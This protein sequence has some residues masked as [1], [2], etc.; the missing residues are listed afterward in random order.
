MPRKELTS[1]SP[2]GVYGLK[3]GEDGLVQVVVTETGE[4]MAWLVD[5]YPR[6]ALRAVFSHDMHRILCLNADGSVGTWGIA[7]RTDPPWPGKNIVDY[8]YFRG[9]HYTIRRR[10]K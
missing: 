8:L 4:T 5:N 1:V 2:D 9:E 3:W 6:W 10:C 7:P